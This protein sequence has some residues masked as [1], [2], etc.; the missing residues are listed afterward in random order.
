MKTPQNLLIAVIL[1][2]SSA[3]FA[4]QKLPRF[5]DGHFFTRKSS[6]GMLPIRAKGSKNPFMQ[7]ESCRDRI[8][9]LM[10]LVDPQKLKARA[11]VCLAASLTA[12]ILKNCMISY[13]R[14]C[15]KC[16]AP[17]A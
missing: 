7:F 17:L 12:F 10:C 13:R 16:F 11:H 6:A 3:G 4:Q 5:P 2:L 1:F 15:R 8:K 14:H 9:S